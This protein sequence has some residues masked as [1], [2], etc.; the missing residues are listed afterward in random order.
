MHVFSYQ[1][2]G[3]YLVVVI[4]HLMYQYPGLIC[5][6]DLIKP[7]TFPKH[8]TIGQNISLNTS[9]FSCPK[10]KIF[11]IPDRQCVYIYCYVEY[12][13]VK[14]VTHYVRIHVFLVFIIWPLPDLRYKS[15][16]DNDL[17]EVRDNWNE[18]LSN[19]IECP[20]FMPCPSEQTMRP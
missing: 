20:I 7:H 11:N 17:P 4:I 2:N 10:R 16:P 12:I 8:Q 3:G 13:S 6:R 19:S 1:P 9:K 15:L 18:F 14:F 5:P